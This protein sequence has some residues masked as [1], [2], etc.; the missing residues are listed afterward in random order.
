[1]HPHSGIVIKSEN[2]IVSVKIESLSACATCES[3]G[4]CGFAEKKDK[5]IDVR[6]PNWDIY[7]QG[8]RVVVSI[9]ETLG[10][11]AVWIAYILPAILDLVLFVFLYDSDNPVSELTCAL[12]SLAFFALYF[13]VLYF[14][15]K[16][17]E[18][19]FTFS[20]THEPTNNL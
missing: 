12:I 9:T 1:M 20:L 18:R 8:D 10:M 11:K 7:Q 4:S 5:V 16:K 19:K 15:R 13:V 3:H 14:F 17:L 2:G 6:T